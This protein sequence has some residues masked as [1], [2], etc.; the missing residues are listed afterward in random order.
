MYFIRSTTSLS[1]GCG[2]LG[3]NDLPDQPGAPAH[4]VSGRPHSRAEHKGTFL[5]LFFVTGDTSPGK[6][7][8]SDICPGD[9]RNERSACVC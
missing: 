5:D 8:L 6:H 4:P 9:R 2:E 3:G 1:A 7:L